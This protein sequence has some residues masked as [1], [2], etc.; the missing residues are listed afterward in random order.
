MTTQTNGQIRKSLG[1]QI[2]RL[3][4]ILN[5]L[6]DG[7][8]QAVAGAVEQAVEAAVRQAVQGLIAE[9][10]TNPDLV[11]AI[12]TVLTT[13][14]NPTASDESRN[15]SSPDQTPRGGLRGW[16]KSAYQACGSRL[17]QAGQ[18]VSWL[19]RQAGAGLQ[20]AVLA[21]A[22]VLAAGTAYVVGPWVAAAAGLVWGWATGLAS[23]TWS[24]LLRMV[25]AFA[26]CGT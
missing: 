5:G 26:L 16:L 9:L 15:G 12:R 10:V 11:A 14:A 17:K 20:A 24:G 7:L 19:W 13:P 25:P 3:E 6:G 22:G 2:Y 23:W 4:H 1:E 18:T 21:G 8:N